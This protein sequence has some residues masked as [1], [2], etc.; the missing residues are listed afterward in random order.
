MI[1]ALTT[2]ENQFFYGTRYIDLKDTVGT[3]FQYELMNDKRK[4]YGQNINNLIATQGR[5]SIK[6]N[7]DLDWQVRQIIVLNSGHRCKIQEIVEMEQEVNPQVAYFALN[8]S[9][10]YF[11]SLVEI[12]NPMELR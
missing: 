3:N 2:N 8:P 9:K 6:T 1:D 7:W 11:L 12:S 5:I 10:S 4:S